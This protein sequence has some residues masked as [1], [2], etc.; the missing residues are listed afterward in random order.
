MHR[1]IEFNPNSPYTLGGMTVDLTTRFEEDG[2]VYYRTNRTRRGKALIVS[3]A[4]FRKTLHMAITQGCG[5]YK[6]V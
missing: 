1:A 5:G 6:L 4:V 2:V 3:K